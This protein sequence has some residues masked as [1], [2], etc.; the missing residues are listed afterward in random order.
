MAMQN[1][2]NLIRTIAKDEDFRKEAYVC[3]NGNHFKEYLG[4]RGY[5]FEPWEF[6]DAATSLLM[7][8]PSQE[9]ADEIREIK[10]WYEFM[11][12]L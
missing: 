6:E 11:I 4:T 2:I 5:T 8:A 1:A 10:H 3:E 12:S 9:A 7:K